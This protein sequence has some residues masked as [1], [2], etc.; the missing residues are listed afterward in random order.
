MKVIVFK[1]TITDV[2]R[3]IKEMRKRQDECFVRHGGKLR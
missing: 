3:Q 2:I 1:G